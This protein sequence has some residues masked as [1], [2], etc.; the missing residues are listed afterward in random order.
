MKRFAR[1]SAVTLALLTAAVSVGTA[2]SP[3]NAAAKP[4]I[5]WHFTHNRMEQKGKVTAVI[6]AID[7][8][9][10][11][12]SVLQEQEGTQGVWRNI[13]TIALIDNKCGTI[14]LYESTRGWFHYRMQ[15]WW[16]HAPHFTSPT[17]SE[18]VYGPVGFLTLC[19]GQSA[20]SLMNGGGT[21]EIGGHLDSYIDMGCDS[22]GPI[23]GGE[24]DD[25]GPAELPWTYELHSNN[26]CRSLSMSTAMLDGNGSK[27]PGDQIT[28]QFIQHTLNAETAY[29]EYNNVSTSTFALDGGPI[30][31]NLTEATGNEIFFLISASADCYTTSGLT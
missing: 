10:G 3:A 14:P 18:V 29:P 2:P 28:I 9:T 22:D 12:N 16:S 23:G 31:I 1:R 19:K 27:A 8:P 30:D 4:S 21:Q 17:E 15:L 11:S 26:S 5:A 6:C 24:C 25:Y 7:A 20:C 13:A